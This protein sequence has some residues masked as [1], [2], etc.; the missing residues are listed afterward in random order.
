MACWNAWRRDQRAY[1]SLPGGFC[2]RC[3]ASAARC[4]CRIAQDP[5][6]AVTGVHLPPPCVPPTARSQLAGHRRARDW[7]PGGAPGWPGGRGGAAWGRRRPL[8][9]TRLPPG[10]AA[11]ASAATPPKRRRRLATQGAPL[12]GLAQP[13]DRPSGGLARF[14][15]TR[16]CALPS[17]PLL[18][19]EGRAAAA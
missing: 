17:L 13:H 10:A 16:G 12:G 9:V 7:R 18:G 15:R 5:P 8:P 3:A 14:S 1:K 4:N 11:A 6:S 19:A 2:G